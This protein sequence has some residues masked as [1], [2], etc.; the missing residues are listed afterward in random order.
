MK[1]DPTLTPF[2]KQLFRSFSYSVMVLKISSKKARF[3]VILSPID[4]KEIL[5]PKNKRYLPYLHQDSIITYIII[6]FQGGLEVQS[7]S[8]IN[9]RGL[10][11]IATMYM[12]WIL[13]F[14]LSSLIIVDIVFAFKKLWMEK[15]FFF[16]RRL[17][18]CHVT[19]CQTL[20]T[21]IM[22]GTLVTYQIKFFSKK[23]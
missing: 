8:G 11:S 17:I 3:L 19:N 2:L 22:I 21:R 7:R 16:N 9:V 13:P 12:P 18:V 4:T 10:E 23:K 5:S 6:Y 20:G 15:L 1:V 14:V